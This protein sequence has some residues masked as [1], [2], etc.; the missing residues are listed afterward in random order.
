MK[1]CVGFCAVFLLAILAVFGA[2]GDG[3]PVYD[4]HLLQKSDIK[5]SCILFRISGVM[6]END[7]QY[8]HD[9][10]CDETGA[11]IGTARMRWGFKYGHRYGG[12]GTVTEGDIECVWQG[13]MGW[14][15][16]RVKNP[17]TC[18]GVTVVP[19]LA[20]IAD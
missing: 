9:I 5:D 16:V 19:R 20:K 12:G 8:V 17:G 1:K 6:R 14:V 13:G 4:P 18:R 15:K 10:F 3:N 2:E 11:K 7:C